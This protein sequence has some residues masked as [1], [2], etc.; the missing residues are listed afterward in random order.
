MGQ[1]VKITSEMKPPL[2]G[3]TNKKNLII[4]L[5]S[6]CWRSLKIKFLKLTWSKFSVKSAKLRL[7]T[8]FLAPINSELPSC[9]SSLKWSEWVWF[10]R[11]ARRSPENTG[12]RFGAKANPSGAA[13]KSETRNT[14]IKFGA[15]TNWNGAARKSR[16]VP[17]KSLPVPGI[18]VS[19]GQ[20]GAVRAC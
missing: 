14:E 13:R 19:W 10:P 2:K 7:Y 12:I 4:R 15:E 20:H 1:K 18:A 6:W 9:R 17:R 5:S 16:T 8:T 3:T 11:K